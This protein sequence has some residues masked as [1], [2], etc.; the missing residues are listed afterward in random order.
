MEERI[1][2]EQT[3][4]FPHYPHQE[5]LSQI[6]NKKDIKHHKRKWYLEL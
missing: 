2:V 1:C 4:A 5:L 3:F 6:G